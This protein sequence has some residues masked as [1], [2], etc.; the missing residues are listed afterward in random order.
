VRAPVLSTL[1]R[2]AGTLLAE[3]PA[4]FTARRGEERAK[5]VRKRGGSAASE[6]AVARALAWLAERQGEDGSWDLDADD[7]EGQGGGWHGERVP[8]PFDYEGTALC[9]LAF[10]G[11]GHTHEQ[12]EHAEAVARALDALRGARGRRPT[13]F[14][15]AYA[16]QAMA[17]AYAMTGDEALAAP[18]REGSTSCSR[19]RKPDAGW[20]YYAGSRMASGTPTTTAV[21][22]ALRIAEEAGFRVDDSY[23]APVLKWLD[24]LVEMKT[25]RV[26]YTVNGRRLGYTPTTANA[27]SALLVR[28]WLGQKKGHPMVRR[29]LRAIAKHKP[30]WSL[31]FKVLEVNGRKRKVQ[32]GYLQHYY[33]W[34]GTE[35]LARLDPGLYSSWN[36]AL[37][38]ALLPKQR[39]SGPLAGSWDPDGTYGKVGGRIFSTALCTLAL[40]SYYRYK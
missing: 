4:M 2:L 5:L 11:A 6:R 12:G 14:G 10:L 9:T 1:L 20:R 27:A 28:A 40:E 34:H 29:H 17:E 13:L 25:G 24:G 37:K 36:R 15:V 22:T 19:S 31:K 7:L 39:K 8:C 3:P 38:R 32:I 35:A 16:T 26:E 21:V 23:R 33:W 18:V 30:K